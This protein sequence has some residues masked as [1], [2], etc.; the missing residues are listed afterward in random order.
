MMDPFEQ[1]VERRV[2]DRL[3][4]FRPVRPGDE[5]NL[6]AF[7]RDRLSPRSQHFFCPHD[8]SRPE[9]CLA[10]FAERV[11]RHAERRDLTLVVEQEGEIV[12]YFFLWWLDRTDGRPPTLG[13]GLA[14]RLHGCGV[15]ARMMDH[16]IACAR[17]LGLPAIKLTHEAA[18]ERAARLYRSRGFVYTGAENP[19]PDGTG[20]EREMWLTLV[21][22]PGCATFGNESRERK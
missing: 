4:L 7:F 19:R 22:R 17:A 12:G 20:V 16:L 13:I 8:P 14:D 3:L 11:R 21:H 18:N 2:A 9:P 1:T 15:G 5:A 6:L 10:Q